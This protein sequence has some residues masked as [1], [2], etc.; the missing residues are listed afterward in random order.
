MTYVDGWD[1][2]AA[3][4][5]ASCLSCAVAQTQPELEKRLC[6]ALFTRDIYYT[7]VPLNNS[8]K[9]KI[10]ALRAPLIPSCHAG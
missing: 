8:L 4:W 3:R 2:K 1:H 6:C 5:R 7:I 9:A 10:T